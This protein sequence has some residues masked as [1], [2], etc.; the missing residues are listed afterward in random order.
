MRKSGKG[1]HQAST[2]MFFSLWV[3]IP[4]NPNP[5]PRQPTRTFHLR[6]SFTFPQE[7][8]PDY[9]TSNVLVTLCR[10]LHFLSWINI[11]LTLIYYISYKTPTPL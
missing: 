3:F 2:Y 10:A 1:L 11:T 7:D 5:N 4:P 8:S 9:K 6:L